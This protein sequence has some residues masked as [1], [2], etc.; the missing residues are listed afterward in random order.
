MNITSNE[1]TARYITL[2]SAAIFFS[3]VYALFI[4]NFSLFYFLGTKVNDTMSQTRYNLLKKPQADE[5]IVL[6]G[7]DDESYQRADRQWPWGR[8][9]FALCL[10]KLKLLEPKVIGLDFTFVGRGTDTDLDTL[11]SQELK[12][13]GNVVLAS[14]FDDQGH[15]FPPS[16]PFRSAAAAAGFSD[17]PVDRDSV[18][19]RV[20]TRFDL[21]QENVSVVSFAA[22]LAYLF[23]GLS[24]LES[25]AQAGRSEVTF[26]YPGK[27][28][29]T[30]AREYL[31]LDS[32]ERIW[33]SY[34]YKSGDFV[35]IPFWKL[36]E[37]QVSRR[38]IK[39]KIVIVGSA[40]P[41]F[42][43]SH[44]TP[45]GTLEGIFIQANETAM[46]L[47]RDFIRPL[48]PDSALWRALIFFAV[49]STLLFLFDLFNFAVKFFLFLS[50]ELMVYGISLFLLV[51]KNILFQPFHPM[52]IVGTSYMAVLFY[53]TFRAFLESA[54][55]QKQA[56]MDD[57]TD[58]YGHR[59]LELRLAAE[60]KRHEEIKKEFCF[61]MIDIDQFKKVNDTYGHEQGNVVLITV[62]KAI[63]SGVRGYDVVAR[64]GGEEFSII[65]S[66]CE[67]KTAIQTAERIRKSIEDLK[68]SISSKNVSVTVSI[69]ICSNKQPGVQNH[70][71][72]KRLADQALYQAKNEG[73]NRVCVSQAVSAA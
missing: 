25:V 68:F 12:E 72:M 4:S 3:I 2:L 14:Y 52:F 61:A 10:K 40:R 66:D 30:S 33:L 53:D 8:D 16:E 65:L 49:A 37:D 31:T 24:P 60:F 19:R 1:K 56:I 13:A 73:R 67:L 64:Y 18:I 17:K 43:D 45:L 70:Q 9:V 51:Q 6:V 50:L 28:D 34:R 63:K 48:Y 41:I 35:Y 26:F 69:G 21:S 44:T 58:L 42:H 38:E 29:L 7:V 46:I 57:L 39:G 15:F 55:L 36:M 62:A 5:R 47:D 11:F 54:E 59:Y 20:H 71:E 27:E 23:M 32:H 22:N